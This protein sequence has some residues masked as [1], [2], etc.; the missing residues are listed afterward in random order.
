MVEIMIA[1]GGELKDTLLREGL[2]PGEVIFKYCWHRYAPPVGSGIRAKAKFES[3]VAQF[4]RLIAMHREAPSTIPM[5]VA[6]VKSTDGEFA[7]YIIEYVEGR[8]LQT[9]I[10]NGMV[11]EARRQLD[12]VETTIGKFHA[13]GMPHGDL[14]ASNIIVADDGRTVLI[15]PVA[16]PG[17]GTKL[18]DEICLDH[19]RKQ[20]DGFEHPRS[21]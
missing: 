6:T 8:T 21:A 14:N 7:G 16:N 9:L 11:A 10:S 15:D 2:D 5:P 1:D 13:K 12:I 17:S 18:Q 19:L 20:I 4:E 3:L